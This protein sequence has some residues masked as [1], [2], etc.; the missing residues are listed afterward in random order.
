MCFLETDPIG[1]A[2]LYSVFSRQTKRD[3]RNVGCKHRTVWERMGNAD[4]NGAGSG[5]D[6]EDGGLMKPGAWNLGH[7]AGGMREEV[8]GARDKYFG[9]WAGDEADAA[10]DGEGEIKKVLTMK[11][12]C[13]GFVFFS[14]TEETVEAP[15]FSGSEPLGVSEVQFFTRHPK[16]VAKQ[17]FGVKCRAAP[18]VCSLF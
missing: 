2:V 12:V 17:E 18:R 11:N 6:I 1:N 15:R 7:E 5:A 14:S 8:N 10:F 9:F 3:R 4:G 13:N 16:C